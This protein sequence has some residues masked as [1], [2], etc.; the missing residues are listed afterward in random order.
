MIHLRDVGRKARWR[1]VSSAWNT[2]LVDALVIFH[3]INS[4]PLLETRHP[5]HVDGP[6]KGRGRSWSRGEALMT[7]AY[8]IHMQRNVLDSRNMEVSAVGFRPTNN[9]LMVTTGRVVVRS[10]SCI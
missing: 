9:M 10:V 6:E 4:H 8:S 1:A 3:V 5:E 7:H 2:R